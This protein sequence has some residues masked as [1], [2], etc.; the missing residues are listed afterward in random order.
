MFPLNTQFYQ[1]ARSG[2]GGERHEKHD[3]LYLMLESED[4]PSNTKKARAIMLP[5]TP[6]H[7]LLFFVF[8]TFL[9]LT[10]ILKEIDPLNV[11]SLR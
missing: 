10:F 4:H 2:E 3:H 6:N 7:G 8:I 9:N 11:F 1:H 5:W